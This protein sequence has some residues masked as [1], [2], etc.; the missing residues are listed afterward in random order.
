[1][2]MLFEHLAGPVPQVRWVA[3]AE[4]GTDSPLGAALGPYTA[5]QQSL[6]LGLLPGRGPGMVVLY[7][8][9]IS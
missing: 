3:A 7:P 4:S 6:A 1:M 2:R 8:W 5:G 9:H